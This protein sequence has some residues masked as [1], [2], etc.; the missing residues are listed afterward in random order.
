MENRIYTNFEKLHF[1]DFEIKNIFAMRQKWK[2]GVTFRMSNPRNST[3]IIF[4]NKAVGIY[5]SAG[6]SFA[7]K[8]KSIVCL[9]QGSRY[10]CLNH[11]CTETLDDAILVSFNII[12]DN[13]ILTFGDE[14]FLLKDVNVPICAQLFNKAVLAYEAAMPSAVEIK[15]AIYQ[16]LAH[17]GKES[18]K[19]RM[20]RFECISTGIEILEQNPL[21]EISVEEIAS[22]CNVTPC[23]FRRLFKEYSGK[24]PLEYRMN[25]KLNMAKRMLESG[26][27]S[28]SYIA[29]SLNFESASYFCRIFKKKFN[30]TPG[31]YRSEAKNHATRII[32]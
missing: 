21:L 16:L 26:D 29:E 2:R 15:A 24:S 28:L 3:G 23:Y 7:A 13:K 9:P 1:L 18:L 11:I 32:Q 6:N 17:I 25:Q 5:G 14:P 8:E 10:T 12:S 31:S 4:L 22:A 30:L 20:E 27:A 19:V